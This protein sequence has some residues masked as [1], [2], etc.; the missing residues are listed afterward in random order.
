MSLFSNNEKPITFSKAYLCALT[1]ELILVLPES[2]KNE[3]S[4]LA[5]TDLLDFPGTRRFENTNENRITDKSLTVLLRRGKVD[6]L[7]NKYSNN[8]RINTLLF[9]QNQ[10]QSAQSVMPEKL[11]RWISKMIG[12]TSV[13]REN[14]KSLISPLFVIS[15]WFN[16]D[17]EFNYNEDTPNKTKSLNERW[18]QRFSKVIEEEILKQVNIL[19]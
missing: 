7:F 1:A 19:G 8:E 18:D 17:L 10:K 13:E 16:K 6:Y 2:I 15:T 11:N 9:C 5:Q 4:F 12:A 3:K 14:F